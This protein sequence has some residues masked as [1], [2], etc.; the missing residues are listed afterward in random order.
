MLYDEFVRRRV[1]DAVYLLLRASI[2]G[3]C[4]LCG[5]YLGRVFLSSDVCLQREFSEFQ[6][7]RKK[8]FEG[9]NSCRMYV[10][11]EE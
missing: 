10:L 9:K 5:E 1:L 8:T 7:T 2:L 11:S 4:I 3:K 6:L